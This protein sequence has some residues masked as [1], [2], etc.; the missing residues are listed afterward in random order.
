MAATGSA[1][2]LLTGR[3]NTC[4]YN[5]AGFHGAFNVS[6]ACGMD[7]A[8]ACPRVENFQKIRVGKKTIAVPNSNLSGSISVFV[9]F[10]FLQLIF[11]NQLWLATK[12]WTPWFVRNWKMFVFIAG[13]LNDGTRPSYIVATR[14]RRVYQL[15]IRISKIFC[16]PDQFFLIYSQP[17]CQS[18]L[19]FMELL[20]FWLRWRWFKTSFEFKKK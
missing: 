6:R 19:N 12:I 2:W 13:L 20:M 10:S 14:G 18:C 11:R 7:I 8:H 4:K 17:S 16:I 5:P 3:D 9:G 15:V 1:R